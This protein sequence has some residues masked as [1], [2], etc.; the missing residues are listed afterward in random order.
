MKLGSAYGDLYL[1]DQL[2]ASN[3]TTFLSDAN[4]VPGSNPETPCT[5]PTYRPA[6]YILSR[7]DCYGY[8]NAGSPGI[9]T[10]ADNFLYDLT[11]SNAFVMGN[12]AGYYAYAD[13]LARNPSGAALTNLPGRIIIN[14]GNLDLTRTTIYDPEAEVVIKAD[15][16]L[17]ITGATVSCR[18]LSFDV[19]SASGNLNI[20]NLSAATSFNTELSGPISAFSIVWTNYETQISAV[21]TDYVSQVVYTNYDTNGVKAT[22]TNQ[23][24][25]NIHVLLVDASGLFT[26]VPVTI[27][28]FIL[29]STNMTVSDPI[30]VARTLLF[31]GRSLTLRTNLTL[32]GD[33]QSWSWLN[34]P[35]LLYFTNNG[36]LS[37]PY[38]AHFGDD[39][40][41]NYAAF[42]N[43]GTI[44]TSNNSIT[45]N[46]DYFQNDGTLYAIAGGVFVTAS[47]GKVENASIISGEDAD[48]SG[49]TL[50]LSNTTISA[51]GHLYFNLT[52]ALY[53]AGS[54]GNTLTCTNGFSLLSEPTI[55]TLMGTTIRSVALNGAEVDHVWAA[56]DR[57]NTQAGFSNNVVVRNLVLTDDG[58]E[59]LFV[60]SGASANN[61]LYVSNLDL[62]GLSDPAY[63]NEIQIAPNLNIYYIT[64]SPL[65]AWVYL[66]SHFAGHFIHAASG[67]TPYVGN[68]PSGPS[69]KFAINCVGSGQIQFT[70]NDGYVAGQTYIVEASTNLS[71]WV[72][73]FTTN[74]PPSGLFQFI[75][76]DASSYPTRFYRVVPQQ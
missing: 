50:Q 66:N 62:S 20:T 11:F 26:K 42:V 18:N 45:I 48:F 54:S 9:G 37:I 44:I 41:T 31:D 2:G 46:S 30:T 34:A 74:A 49:G 75:I 63:E 33:V 14:A 35:T 24:Q 40:P 69:P 39:G 51:K 10:P 57:G 71:N 32:S 76:P 21:W 55:G 23:S 70:V 12:Y 36:V 19:G 3:N 72:P 7:A 1:V 47:T 17:S 73:I 65:G 68:P 4:Y 64:N 8:F 56:V 27:Q 58:S 59:P 29:H 43:Y 15:N 5:D 38:D 53:D 6:N 16:L 61:G 22:L 67:I 28:D 52:N 25:I 13:N 60:F